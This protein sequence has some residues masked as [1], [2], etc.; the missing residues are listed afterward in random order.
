MKGDTFPR[1]M[2][3]E[4]DARFL[5]LIFIREDKKKNSCL[6]QHYRTQIKACMIMFQDTSDDKNEQDAEWKEDNTH[7]WEAHCWDHK[8]H[9]CQRRQ[10]K[11]H[12]Y[13]SIIGH[14]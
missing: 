7:E 9:T 3:H 10:K 8:S 13:E 1:D 12:I 4:W 2:S 5:N 11:S 6:W 14:R